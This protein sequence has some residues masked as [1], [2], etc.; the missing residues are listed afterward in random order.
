MNQK[1][2]DTLNV[3]IIYGMAELLDSTDL[4][5][6]LRVCRSIHQVVLPLLYHTID[7]PALPRGVHSK[8]E[9]TLRHRMDLAHAVKSLAV[10][11]QPLL[12]DPPHDELDFLFQEYDSLNVSVLKRCSNIKSLRVHGPCDL[13]AT[14]HLQLER[15]SLCSYR[16]SNRTPIDVSAIVMQKNL[17]QLAVGLNCILPHTPATIG[18]SKLPQLRSISGTVDVLELFAKGRPVENYSLVIGGGEHWGYSVRPFPEVLERLKRCLKLASVPLRRLRVQIPT[19]APSEWVPQIVEDIA[20]EQNVEALMVV[21]GGTRPA[22]VSLKPCVRQTF[23]LSPSQL[24]EIVSKMP[25]LRIFYLVFTRA[26]Y[27]QHLYP[28]DPQFC[29]LQS[30]YLALKGRIEDFRVSLDNTALKAFIAWQGTESWPGVVEG[31]D[32]LLADLAEAAVWG[33]SSS[34]YEVSD[35]TV[36]EAEFWSL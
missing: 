19:H 17:V 21:C 33:E 27:V 5:N 20:V 13:E 36:F 1:K 24:L 29:E 18:P 12:G 35:G 8:L 3:D 25:S 15:L 6:L 7:F 9:S 14:R 10:E 11:R 32:S 34:G 16:S 30:S 31:E 28:S 22:P 2:L 26:S 23:T 4:F